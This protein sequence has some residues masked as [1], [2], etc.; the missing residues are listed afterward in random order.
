M[1]KLWACA[2]LFLL[3]V[4][5]SFP[6][7]LEKLPE[8]SRIIKKRADFR[9]ALRNLIKHEGFYSNHW[10]DYGKE[11]YMGISRR[12]Y[13]DFK[14]WEIIDQYKI[15]NKVNW[16][17]SIPIEFLNWKVN[18]FYLQIWIDGH[19]DEIEDQDIANY[20]LNHTINSTSGAYLIKKTLIEMGY[21]LIL[22]NNMDSATVGYLNIVPKWEF[23]CKL[24]N[25]RID[26][27]VG[28]TERRKNQ[29][30]FLQG[31]MRRTKAE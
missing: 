5:C 6:T 28:I 25:N 21:P 17:D 18:E 10:A 16:N 29:M 20:V 23:L 12:I 22:N 8:K 4:F 27:Y 19:Y 26:F 7:N 3:L 30:V 14:G 2:L 24:M 11:T 9:V 1:L 31:W 15:H 13:P